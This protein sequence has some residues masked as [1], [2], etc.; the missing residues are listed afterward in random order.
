M[1]TDSP[2]LESMRGWPDWLGESH[3]FCKED[4]LQEKLNLSSQQVFGRVNDL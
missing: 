4:P 1:E 3:P 2:A